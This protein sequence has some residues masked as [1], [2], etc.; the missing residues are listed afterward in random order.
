MKRCAAFVLAGLVFAACSI[1][2]PTGTRWETTF[3]LVAAPETLFVNQAGKSDQLYFDP[4]SMLIFSQEVDTITAH[5]GDSLRWRDVSGSFNI[6]LAN[7]VFEDQG[8]VEQNL[9]FYA[10]YPQYL[11]F[12][13]TQQQITESSDFALEVTF[14]DWPDLEWIALSGGEYLLDIS[15]SWPF[16]MEW[17]EL[18][19]YN[20]YGEV[21]GSQRVEPEGGLP[22]GQLWQGQMPMSGLLTASLSLGI[23]G[24]NLPM[25]APGL[26]E[27][28]GMNIQLVQ[29]YS[30]A[31]SARAVIPAQHF[32]LEDSLLSDDRL[33]IVE[34]L[35]GPSTLTIN[36]TENIGLPIGME[37]V[38]PQFLGV[39]SSDPLTLA[40]DLDGSGGES[41]YINELEALHFIDEDGSGLQYFPI[42]FEASTPESAGMQTLISGG[43]VSINL[44][45][46]E[47]S[48][49]TFSGYF[50]ED[51]V[52]PIED[53]A[54][55]FDPWPAELEMLDMSD[56]AM[57]FHIRNDLNVTVESTI[58][59]DVTAGPNA[60]YGD[61]S[62]V[63]TP[64]VTA[65]DTLI[66][67]TGVGRIASR[68]PES[69]LVGGELVLPRDNLFYLDQ[70]SIMGITAIEMAAR[71]R[72]SGF[73]WAS[74]P[75]EVTEE[76]PQEVLEVALE[77]WIDNRIPVGG[78][79]R[80]YVSQSMTGPGV[81]LYN[82]E[83]DPAIWM[84]DSAM[85]VRD[86]VRV[87]LN[88]DALDVTHANPWYI[89]Y[90]FEAVAPEDVV[91]LR[92]HQWMRVQTSFQATIDVD[93][94]GN[95]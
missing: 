53:E 51:L 74:I 11:P 46:S 52:V 92:S 17:V 13:G 23:S 73:S 39:E 2:D 26:I 21:L 45:F 22:A 91:E 10:A 38:F 60:V 63:L 88:G 43:S 62:L 9:P 12:D 34:A 64:Q 40:F 58:T 48:L 95:N 8:S 32:L 68:L 29:V 71:F 72:L 25:D 59:L 54:A 76:I 31:D 83:L 80:G 77:S 82:I 30:E 65:Q 79:L 94:E 27:N 86:T 78:A 87:E 75:E 70:S 56:M 14:P 55:L 36:S 37:I 81:E 85:A 28:G 66:R 90:E 6:Q 33:R 15:H 49:E 19:I 67:L 44:S 89:W 18:A 5:V 24:S 41:Q 4:D 61:T 7:L 57:R 16:D 84:E 42:L 47:A 3:Q 1:E 20:S 69:I 35:S 93:L 50:L